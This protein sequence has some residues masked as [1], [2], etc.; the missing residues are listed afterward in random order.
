MKIITA[1]GKPNV[2]LLIGLIFWDG[3]SFAASETYPQYWISSQSPK[4][5][6]SVTF[7]IIKG[8]S[9]F[10]CNRAF[11]TSF[12]C[13][14]IST[15]VLPGCVD[16]FKLTVKYDTTN[17]WI[18][19]LFD[20]NKENTIYQYTLNGEVVY[21]TPPR[22]CDIPGYF[23]NSEGKKSICNPKTSQIGG[24][25]GKC[26]EPLYLKQIG[27][28]RG[29]NTSFCENPINPGSLYGPQFELGKLARDII[30]CMEVQILQSW[31]IHFQ[32]RMPVQQMFN[33]AKI[34]QVNRNKRCQQSTYRHIPEF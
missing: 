23:Y 28:L 11:I 29:T 19:S 1:S 3:S 5:G 13:S 10:S 9:E 34:S 2:R 27:L 25:D 12:T 30:R 14:K 16:T 33:Q 4:T 20:I 7:A 6:D 18:D 8:K 26:P 32:F 21:Y 17:K 31:C 22:C 15:C 24:G